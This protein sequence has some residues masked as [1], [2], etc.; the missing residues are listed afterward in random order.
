MR[1]TV[2]VDCIVYADPAPTITWYDPD[3][4]EIVNDDMKYS[5]SSSTDP[6]Q[7]RLNSSL[8]VK[9]LIRN[10]NGN[11]KCETQNDLTDE[12][13][14]KFAEVVVLGKDSY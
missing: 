9:N 10:D 5:V 3:S 13:D 11:Y 8:S 1:E 2:V 12:V 7:G 6:D 4:V 14:Q